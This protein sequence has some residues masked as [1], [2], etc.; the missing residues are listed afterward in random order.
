VDQFRR[1]ML[2]EN[3]HCRTTGQ[4]GRHSSADEGGGDITG[5][6]FVPRQVD[7]ALPATIAASISSISPRFSAAMTCDWA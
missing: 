7:R 6:R 2:C 4:I 5:D 3:R 1:S